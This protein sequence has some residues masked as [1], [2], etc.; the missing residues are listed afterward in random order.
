ML[1]KIYKF[2]K[3]KIKNDYHFYLI[4]KIYYLTNFKNDNHVHEYYLTKQ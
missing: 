2:Y 1:V 4:K 3:I